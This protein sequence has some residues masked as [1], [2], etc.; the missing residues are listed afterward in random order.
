MLLMIACTL[1]VL[2][3]LADDAAIPEKPITAEE[4][5]HWAFQPLKRPQVPAVRDRARVRNPIDAFVV[6]R[7]EAEGL[8]PSPEADRPTLL[9]RL[10]FD[11]TGLPPTPAEIDV[12]SSDP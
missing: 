11:L 9:R 2:L 3:G 7:L 10:S 4:R 8:C 12:F 1:G 5:A 6:A